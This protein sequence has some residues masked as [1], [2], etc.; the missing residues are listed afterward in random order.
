MINQ[1]VLKYVDPGNGYVLSAAGGWLVALLLTVLG[2]F[3]AFFKNIFR[4][5]KKFSVLFLLLLILSTGLFF[6]LKGVGMGKKKV[7]F[8]KKVIILGIDALS[9][10]IIERMIDEGKLPNFSY[11]K[12]H[13]SYSH[14]ATTNPPQSP[15]AWAVFATG[16][17]PAKNGI[18][19]FIVRDPQNYSLSLVLSDFKKGVPQ[20]VLKEKAFWN[21]ASETGVPVVVL[22][23]P[24]TFPPDKIQGKMLSGMGV[25]DIL[26]TEGTFTFYTTAP[27]DNNKDIGGKVF[28]VAKSRK[29]QMNLIGPRVKSGEED[30]HL[31]VPFTAVLTGDSAVNIKYQNTNFNLKAG[32]WSG[33]KEVVFRQGALKRIKG[34]F[35]FYLVQVDPELKLYISPINFDPRAPLFPISYPHRYSKELAGSIGLFHTQGMPM[36]TW[37]LN[38]GRLTED[39]FFEEFKKTAKESASRFIFE[40]NR[41]KKGVFFCYFGSVDTAQH[42]FWRQADQS[43][44]FY[45]EKSAPEYRGKIEEQYKEMDRMVGLALATLKEGDTLLVLSDHGFASFD[46]AA[47]VNSWLKSAGYLVLKDHNNSKGREL[48]LDVDWSKTR[49]YALGFGAI[50][51][52]QRGREGQGI[53]E[54]GGESEAL[55][56]ELSEKLSRWQDQ[57][58]NKRVVMRVYK[59]EEIFRGPYSERAPDLYI[60]FEKGYRASWQTALGAVPDQLLEDNQ[61]KWGGDH[62]F[63]PSLVPGVVFSNIKMNN[64]RPSLYSLAPTILKLIGFSD[65][66]L[67]D[68]GFD[69]AVL[70]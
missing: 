36:D 29:M 69:G 3:G 16:K 46:R 52:N 6:L 15:V 5:F 39:A 10:D 12:T 45:D 51:L 62:L 65:G 8:D 43:S 53:V 2:L 50:Y 14:L 61:K 44:S 9:P 54:P 55:K 56:A 37:A 24:V 4:P 26:G 47:H 40:L 25:P 58:N 32:Q 63:D 23:C 66:Q 48:F 1:I 27:L 41:F 20:R 22:S 21:Y 67:K 33:W 60:G 7:P 30:A 49:A 70:F 11:L 35:K 42:M 64:P 38:E 28:T 57:K 17:N 18:F 34:I 68:N 31:V 13:G 19:D 59:K